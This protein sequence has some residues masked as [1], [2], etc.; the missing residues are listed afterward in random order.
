MQERETQIHEKKRDTE[1]QRRP[2]GHHAHNHY[3]FS[4]NPSSCIMT[5]PTSY[6]PFRILPKELLIPLRSIARE[7]HKHRCKSYRPQILSHVMCVEQ[8]PHIRTY[9]QHLSITTIPSFPSPPRPH[10]SIL[11]T[12][13]YQGLPAPHTS[14]SQPKP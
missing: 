12:S 10:H 1:Q 4:S 13:S 11:T 8:P 2:S 9:V 5:I 3:S 14:P 6:H 7:R